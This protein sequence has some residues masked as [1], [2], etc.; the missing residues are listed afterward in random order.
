MPGT[1]FNCDGALVR[2]CA[3]PALRPGDPVTPASEGRRQ[4]RQTDTSRA[5]A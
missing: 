5:G 2:S 4:L 3:Q 1:A